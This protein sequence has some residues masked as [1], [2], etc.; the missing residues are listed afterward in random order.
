[1]D[2]LWPIIVKN[3]VRLHEEG[4]TVESAKLNSL[5]TDLDGAKEKESLEVLGLVKWVEQLKRCQASFEEVYQRRIEL[6]TAKDI[7]TK[8]VSKSALSKTLMVL[9]SGLQFLT[10]SKPDMDYGAT[11]KV[12]DDIIK[13]IVATERGR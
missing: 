7:P 10:M 5:F 9:I 6:E 1:M 8:A 11:N 12:V 3:G 2:I 4:F 13:R